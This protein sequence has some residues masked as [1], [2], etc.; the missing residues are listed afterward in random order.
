MSKTS[1][2]PHPEWRVLQQ[3]S[4]ALQS[5]IA[6]VLTDLHSLHDARPVVIGRYAAAFADRL[7]RLHELEIGAA[8]LKREAELVQ[9]CIN[10][11]REIDYEEIQAILDAEFAEWQA[12][13][14]AEIDDLTHH[15]GMLQYLLDVKI[16]RRLRSC[17]R[18]LARRLH[19]DLHPVQTNT[20]V[21]LWHRVLAAYKAQDVDELEALELVTRDSR[22]PDTADSMEALRESVL[23]F[24]KQLDRLLES[25][26]KR[27]KEWPFNQLPLLEDPAA[28][29]ARQAELDERI[30][31]GEALRDE[32]SHWLNQLLDH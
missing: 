25:H 6:A 18:V 23:R 16:A 3:E 31:T 12:R 5:Q 21:E 9:A 22:Q 4:E 13:L 8:R 11:G 26:A 27:R 1:P 30:T 10:T 2:I 19:P 29:A 7:F 28:V 17:F 14:E 32:R 24:R 20:D 15:R